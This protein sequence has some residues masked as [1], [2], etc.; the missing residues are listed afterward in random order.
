MLRTAAH[1]CVDNLLEGV[2]LLLG[3]GVMLFGDLVDVGLADI[4]ARLQSRS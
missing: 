4:E 2:S 3:G 1:Q